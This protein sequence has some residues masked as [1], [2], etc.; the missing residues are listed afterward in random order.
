MNLGIVAINHVGLVTK[1]QAKAEEFYIGVLG[2]RRH[3]DVDSWFHLNESLL[4]HL[5][6]IPEATVD[7]SLYHE[8]QHFALQVPNLD[9]VLKTLI[10]SRLNPFQMDFE[11][12]IKQVV[13][14][15]DDLEFGIGTLFVED[16]DGNLVEFL[17]MGKGKFKEI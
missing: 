7:K 15:D 14:R 1:D 9:L 5:I 13:S 16:P 17:Q 8:V 12:N 2:L 3:K 11:G 4:L 6:E 10:D